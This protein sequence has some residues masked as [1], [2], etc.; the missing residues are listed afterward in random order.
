MMRD[1]RRVNVGGMGGK[2][3]TGGG[4]GMGEFF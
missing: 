4:V 1:C 2:V 3:Q